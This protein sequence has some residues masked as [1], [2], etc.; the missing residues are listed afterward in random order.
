MKRIRMIT[1]AAGPA[2]VLEPGRVY[3]VEDERAQKL[4]AAGAAV[5]VEPQMAKA[6]IEAA[7]IEPEETATPARRKRR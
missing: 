6:P 5:A 2:G 4:V 1:L 3:E 7:I